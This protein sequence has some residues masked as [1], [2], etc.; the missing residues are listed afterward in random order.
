MKLTMAMKWQAFRRDVIHPN[1]PATQVIEMR[2]A[3]YAGSFAILSCLETNLSVLPD[4][5][6]E[7]ETVMTTLV[8][9]LAAFVEDVRAHRA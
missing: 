8:A 5:T 1:A 3:F 2:R 7:D 9:E 6:P 4:S